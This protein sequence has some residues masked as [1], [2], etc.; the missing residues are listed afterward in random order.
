MKRILSAVALAAM[1]A[2][3]ALPHDYELGDLKLDHPWARATT[4]VA[5]ASGGFLSITNE[6]ETDDTL[7]EARSDIAARL[8]LHLTED[9][10]GVM[11]MREVEGGIPIPAGETVEL[12]PGSFH[13][14]F[15]GLENQLLEGESYPVTL[16]FENAGE[17]IVDFA[18]ENRAG[19]MDHSGHGGGET[20]H[21][22]DE[23]GGHDH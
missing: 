7:I 8:E 12:R 16:V 14:M 11:R 15:M 5:R 9:D 2:T 3:P 23:H 19:G 1:L 13:V 6:G 21:G 17:I 18:A 22:D 10:D 20:D 4:T